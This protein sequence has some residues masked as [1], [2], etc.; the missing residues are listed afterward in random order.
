LRIAIDTRWIAG[1]TGGIR[2]YVLNLVKSLSRIDTQNDYL[3]VYDQE[4]TRTELEGNIGEKENFR[5]AQVPYG[6]FSWRSQVFL[7]RMLAKRNVDVF[8]SPNFMVPLFSSGYRTVVSFHDLIPYLH[9][10]WCIRSKKNRIYPIYKKTTE[11]IARKADKILTDSR[12]SEQDILRVFPFARKKVEAV[13]VGV[14]EEFR[15]IGDEA[16]IKEVK[17]RY[18]ITK[19]CVL[20]VG[21][22][23]PSKNLVGLIAAFEK[24]RKRIDCCLLV[25]GKKDRRYP[26]AYNLVERLGLR[27]DVV[28][29]GYV[30]PEL[31]PAI[32]NACDL[33]AFPSFYEGFGLPPLEAMACGLPVVCSNAA[34]LPEVVA[35]AAALV[36]PENIRGFAEKMEELFVDQRLREKM[37]NRGFA[38]AKFFS[39]SKAA[40]ETL[41]A[42][43]T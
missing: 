27:N 40:E 1:D 6:P 31:L 8:H 18:R 5:Y 36:D 13:Y 11:I 16:I 43:G 41:R 33:F 28:F 35:N 10:K 25:V 42:Y 34:S 30:V 9:P 14:G 21:R 26:E 7:P 29:A 24:L 23:D 39:W 12:H 17:H 2:Q 32:Y 38:R 15:V 3:L 4:R 19:R 22:Q 20:Y 37:V